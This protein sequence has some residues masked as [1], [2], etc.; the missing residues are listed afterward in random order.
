MS[1]KNKIHNLD[2]EQYGFYEATKN[3]KFS[4]F[5]NSRYVFFKSLSE[6]KQAIYQNALSIGESL[7]ADAAAVLLNNQ[8]MK[9]NTNTHQNIQAYI[10]F[11]GEMATAEEANEQEF[12]KKMYNKLSKANKINKELADK[13]EQ[14][15]SN[16]GENYYEM[17]NL[18]NNIITLNNKDQEEMQKRYQTNM[19]TLK[20]R[21]ARLNNIEIE[22][23]SNLNNTGN[24]G[25]F[26][27]ELSKVVNEI[28][29]GE[30]A[31]FGET[32]SNLVARKINSVIY[33]LG[34]DTNLMEYL[35]IQYS[36]M[37]IEQLR[38]ALVEYIVDFIDSKGYTELSNTDTQ[39][40]IKEITDTL[41]KKDALINKTTK[42]YL[43][44]IMNDTTKKR[45]KVIRTLEEVA[46]TTGKDTARMFQNLKDKEQNEFL[47]VNDGYG[48]WLK[49]S[50]ID[51]LKNFLTNKNS[52]TSKEL[53]NASR[54]INKAIRDKAIEEIGKEVLDMSAQQIREKASHMFK[55]RQQK[56]GL[57]NY[58]N[59][60][61]NGPSIA[62]IQGDKEFIENVAETVFRGGTKIKLK[63]DLVAY[64]SFDEQAYKAANKSEQSG[65]NILIN[66]PQS[67]MERYNEKSGGSTDVKAAK[68][69]YIETIQEQINTIDMAYQKQIIDSQERE[70]LLNAL[71][72]D[73]LSGI[74]IKDYQYG[75]NEFGFHGGSL[76][77]N[78]ESIMNN[79][80]EMYELGGISKADADILAFA[81]ANCGNEL[82]GSSLKEPL[83]T[84]ILGAAAIMMFDE[85]FTASETFL[86][87][88]KSLLGF[89]G[90]KGL[91]LFR[92]QTGYLSASFVYKIIYNNLN[93]A[94]NDIQSSL[95]EA[96]SN[97]SNKVVI[98]NNI[99]SNNIPHFSI[100][101]F[102]QDRWDAVSALAYDS[103]KVIN[104]NFIFMAGL[105]DVFE[106]IGNAFNIG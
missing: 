78:I 106:A 37:T 43:S 12:I 11:I 61:I 49:Q 36:N 7:V 68:E 44:S 51:A 14:F 57:K 23:L 3:K 82:L 79:I 90:P 56:D 84:Y 91:H 29:D 97:A 95:P 105:L 62:E 65:F 96:M 75:T 1:K 42:S 55:Q 76:G 102:P 2:Y 48:K 50:G 64:I 15:F 5:V 100:V 101:P 59:I 60:R 8:N 92:L 53:E 85:G 74:S 80:S 33:N 93:M 67:F 40:I 45:E 16:P 46:L 98:N 41:R 99:S 86:K 22:N 54:I 63:N 28:L 103:D 71:Q 73:F 52:K 58:L 25:K 47:S 19:T 31:D 4:L 10:N 32:Y 39:S 9:D 30:K 72:N 66:L 83:Q 89:T 35:E 24:I 26:N 70:Q 38:N 6:H 17:Q 69:A 34:K 21:L 27:S 87:Q 20:N 13:F 81:A 94:Y 104:V 18:L 77:G 88:M